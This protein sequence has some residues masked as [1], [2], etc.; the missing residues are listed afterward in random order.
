[1]DGDLPTLPAAESS[2]D[3]ALL[4]N[5]NYLGKLLVL[6][7]M[8]GQLIEAAKADGDLR[9]DLPSGVVLLTIHAR[10]CDPTVDY[11]KMTGQYD[12]RQIIELML[13]TSFQGLLD[14]GAAR[15]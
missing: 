2:L 13:S 14:N 5:G 9:A 15:A 3:D 6:N 7:E 4:G 1:M 12:D 11:L 10:S 8:L